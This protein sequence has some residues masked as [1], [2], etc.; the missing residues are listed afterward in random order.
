MRDQQCSGCGRAKE[1]VEARGTAATGGRRRSLD[2]REKR[3]WA[4]GV[5]PCRPCS[6]RTSARRRVGHLVPQSAREVDLATA[7]V[8]LGA[9]APLA[10]L[11]LDLQAISGPGG[12]ERCT[13]MASLAAAHHDLLPL[14]VDVLDPQGEALEQAEAAAVEDL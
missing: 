8:E 3:V 13:V 2:G 11:E 1:E 9:M 12:Q 6:A 4:V 5:G 7:G 10:L 14:Q